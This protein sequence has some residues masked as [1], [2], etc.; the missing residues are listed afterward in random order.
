MDCSILG[1]T[2]MF[3]QTTLNNQPH[4]HHIYIYSRYIYLLYCII[5]PLLKGSVQQGKALHLK[6]FPT[7]TPNMGPQN[8]TME[9]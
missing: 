2:E 6:S 8:P 3:V 4:I 7:I 5:Y 9:K 1:T